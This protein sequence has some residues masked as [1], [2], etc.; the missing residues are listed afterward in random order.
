MAGSSKLHTAAATMTPAAKPNIARWNRGLGSPA[1]KN[2]MAAPSVVIKNVKPV[3]NA[4]HSIAC[5]IIFSALIPLFGR[6]LARMS[7]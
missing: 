5:N 7:V 2:T 4:A 6:T 1:K 3:P